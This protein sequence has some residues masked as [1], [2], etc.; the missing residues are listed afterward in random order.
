MDITLKD[1]IL[2]VTMAVG[3]GGQIATTRLWIDRLTKIVFDKNGEVRVVTHTALAHIMQGC[4]DT[5]ELQCNN[6]MSDITEIKIDLDRVRNSMDKHHS[7]D[8][9][10]YSE[11]YNC[12]SKLTD[13]LELACK[14]LS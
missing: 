12:M 14:G 10:K 8:A 6:V 7:S 4:R 2:W 11:I 13:K 9:A 1:F 5:N 3:F